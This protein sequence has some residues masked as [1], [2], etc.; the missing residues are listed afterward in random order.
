MKIDTGAVLVARQRVID[1]AAEGVAEA[2]LTGA[3]FEKAFAE[4]VGA[5][6][7]PDAKMARA[8][9]PAVRELATYVTAG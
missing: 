1:R 8:Y 3:S 7:E 2:M 6:E 9:E 4:V 5:F